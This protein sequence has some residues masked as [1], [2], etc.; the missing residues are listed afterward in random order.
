MLNFFKKKYRNIDEYPNTWSVGQ[1]EFN[2]KPLIVRYRQIKEAEGH[3]DYPFQIGV[4]VPFLKNTDDGL[5]ENEDSDALN[6]IEDKLADALEKNKQTV[7]V[8]TITTNNMRE[9]VFYAKEW[10]PESFEKEIKELNKSFPSHFLQFM[11]KQD[12]KW[13]TF[14]QFVK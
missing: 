12:P 13:S 10:K 11:M 9:F 7:F 3:P 4:A 6:G 8:L 2:G 14:A 1:G 5:P